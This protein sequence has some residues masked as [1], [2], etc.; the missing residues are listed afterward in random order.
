MWICTDNRFKIR[1]QKLPV[2]KMGVEL[3]FN[4]LW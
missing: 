1:R 3:L 4:V 2:A